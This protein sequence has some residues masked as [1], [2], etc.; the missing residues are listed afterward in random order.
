VSGDFYTIV[1]RAAGDGRARRQAPSALAALDKREVSLEVTFTDGPK[2]AS[3]LAARAAA[4]GRRRFL[5]VGGD[6]TAS[7]VVNGLV[8]AGVAEECELAMLPL[9]T[10]NSFLRDFG[11]TNVE[12]ACEAIVRGRSRPIDVVRVTHDEGEIHFINTMGTGFVAD[13]G[14]LTNA[15]F[16][17]LG[18]AG[19][20][21]AVLVCIARLEYEHN[22]LK[23]DGT[24][25]DTET[26]LTSFSNSQYTGGTMWMAPD[27][28][29][30][31]GLLDIVRA[32]RLRRGE[33]T[34]AFAKIFKG[35]HTKLDKVWTRQ[36]DRVEFVRPT[37]QA[38]L[39]D[40]DL[41]HLTPLAI[42]VLP[43]ALR[44]IA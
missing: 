26:V 14:E 19:Y 25:D 41:F 38:V 7:E 42:D 4:D 10:G 22:A 40:G 30:A 12:A 37:R 36:V 27:A 29:V 23:Y 44:L 16:K 3:E 1:N 32:G 34:A 17:F 11:I 2:H 6:G 21:A 18:A 20:V 31:D 35:T 33:L 5:S 8:A 15:R 9:G 24:L 13:A 39:I 43:A 28:D